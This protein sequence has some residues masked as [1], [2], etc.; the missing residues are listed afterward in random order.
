VPTDHAPKF[1]LRDLLSPESPDPVHIAEQLDRLSH[2]QRVLALRGMERAQLQKLYAVFEG[3]AAMTLSDLVPAETPPLQAVRHIGRNSLPLF[4]DFEKRFY[5]LHTPAAVGGA[6]FQSTSALTG[7]GYFTAS[8]RGEPA[9]VVIDY[10]QIPETAPQGWPALTDNDHGIGRFVYGGM[11]D[12]L[13]R[14][15]RHV[16]IGAA[17]KR[18][19]APSAFFV[20]TR[21]PNDADAG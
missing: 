9:E 11:I 10:N 1:V 12:T 15:S 6:N 14:V 19:Q 7:P 2:P 5:R 4:S 21:L 20:L 17:Q 13:R 18:G 8:V 3:F 16:S